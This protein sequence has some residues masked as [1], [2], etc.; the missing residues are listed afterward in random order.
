MS[1][2]EEEDF[3]EEEEEDIDEPAKKPVFYAP[4]Q[5]LPV[6]PLITTFPVM[7][8][9]QLMFNWYSAAKQPPSQRFA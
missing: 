8:F 9:L 4:K 1:D 5:P 3:E 7:E 2:E 6:Q